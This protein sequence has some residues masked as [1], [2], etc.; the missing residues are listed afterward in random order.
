MLVEDSFKTNEHMCC[1]VSMKV[2]EIKIFLSSIRL[3]GGSVSLWKRLAVFCW[4][5]PFLEDPF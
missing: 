2:F 3:T 5:F 1:I 4:R